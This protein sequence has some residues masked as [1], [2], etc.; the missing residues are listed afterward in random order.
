MHPGFAD[1]PISIPRQVGISEVI[2]RESY[3]MGSIIELRM[4]SCK[5]DNAKTS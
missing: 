2:A 5:S 3:S 4:Q 1:R